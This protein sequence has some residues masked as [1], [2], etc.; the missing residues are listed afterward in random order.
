MGGTQTRVLIVDDSR[1][2]RER[3]TESLST[4]DGAD[5]VGTAT[6]AQ[7]GIDL[8]QSLTPDVVILDIRMPEGSGL[9]VLELINNSQAS[10]TVVMLTNYPYPQYRE[11]CMELGADFFFDKTREFN[12]VSEVVA[13]LTQGNR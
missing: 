11:R 5:I 10:P 7:E 4:I 9:R 13:N 8:F 1:H 2:I 12:K 3:L 6:T